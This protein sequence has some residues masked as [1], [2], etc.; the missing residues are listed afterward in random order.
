MGGDCIGRRQSLD[1]HICRQGPIGNA[2]QHLRREKRQAHDPNDISTGN[3]FAPSD[4][5]ERQLG[6]GLQ[7]LPPSAALNDGLHERTINRGYDRAAVLRNQSHHM[8]AA[9][10]TGGHAKRH[11]LVHSI[12]VE[13][14]PQ[15]RRVKYDVDLTGPEVHLGNKAAPVSTPES[16]IPA[17]IAIVRAVAA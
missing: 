13:H 17:C 16:A 2:A 12:I 15:L 1:R 8:T 14:G 10:E 11:R 5:F 9:F 6:V 7:F 3:T 4:V